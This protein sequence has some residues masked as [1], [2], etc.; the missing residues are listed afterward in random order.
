M[1]R[2]DVAHATVCLD[3]LGRRCLW[4]SSVK[5]PRRL[6]RFNGTGVVR[7]P[8]CTYRVRYGILHCDDAPAACN[9]NDTSNADEHFY[10][11]CRDGRLHRDGDEPAV[12][13]R[14]RLANGIYRHDQE[15]YQH[16]SL[17]HDTLPAR[18]HEER[19][20]NGGYTFHASEWWHKGVLH[21]EGQPAI[22][23]MEYRDDGY[24]AINVKWLQHGK[25]HRERASLERA[26]VYEFEWRPTPDCWHEYVMAAR[27]GRLIAR[28]IRS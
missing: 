2:W 25:L 15:R 21:R 23:R 18:V 5:A 11:W 27:H 13:T 22:V 10:V 9:I 26:T 14:T 19:G 1:P 24:T 8:Q 16:G 12:D 28:D 7:S 6:M 20:D 3:D 4:T 17:H